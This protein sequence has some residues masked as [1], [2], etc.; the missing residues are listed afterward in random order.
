MID[1]SGVRVPEEDA[2]TGISA[3][4]LSQENNEMFVTSYRQLR[5]GAEI[6][7]FSDLTIDL[8]KLNFKGLLV[9]WFDHTLNLK[10]IEVGVFNKESFLLIVCIFKPDIRLIYKTYRRG[11]TGFNSLIFI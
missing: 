5:E 10:N 4:Y 3:L 2:D 6:R 7:I 1:L 11:N 8:I 9:S